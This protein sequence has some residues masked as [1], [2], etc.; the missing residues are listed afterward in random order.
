MIRIRKPY[1]LC[2][3]ILTLGYCIVGCYTTQA[4]PPYPLNGETP[5]DTDMH[6][7]TTVIPTNT[8]I[9][10]YFE[11]TKLPLNSKTL[12]PNDVTTIPPKSIMEYEEFKINKN[13]PIDTK[14]MGGL[15]LGGEHSYIQYFDRQAYK[16]ELSDRSCLSTSPDGNWYSYCTLSSDSPTGKWLIVQS[17]DR[18]QKLKL[19]LDMY[20]LSLD[21]RSWLNNQQLIFS[22][23]REH[24]VYPMVIINPFLGK[25]ELQHL[26]SNYPGIKSSDVGPSGTLQ[27]VYSHLVYDP[28]LNLVVYPRKTYDEKTK[29]DR[30]LI[31]L[32][33]RKA[34]K[35]LAEIEDLLP[36]GHYPDW[37]PNAQQFAIAV[38][39]WTG[40]KHREYIDDWFEVDKVGRVNRLTH[41]VGSFEHVWIGHQ[42]W[43]PD[44]K[45]LAFW[46]DVGSGPCS[47]DRLAILEIST[48]RITNTC[49]PGAYLGGTAPPV[50]SLDGRYIAIENTY[51]IDS[52]NVILIDMEERWA[53]KIGE[54]AVPIGWVK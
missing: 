52:S 1:F 37:S 2:L 6:L 51:D 8:N 30:N 43:S 24:E 38:A 19:P 44:G 27:F 28:S 32:W 41:F 5:R 34:R 3:V 15:I 13:W 26:D 18:Y 12:V 33:D 50:W 23:F 10:E 48:G 29:T 16:E 46:L 17:A 40:D 47:G 53:A 9:P 20:L 39:T 36:F 11:A 25:T 22:I 21:P 45:K 42:S 4:F 7:D 31:I 14:I 35:Q 49:I 54:N